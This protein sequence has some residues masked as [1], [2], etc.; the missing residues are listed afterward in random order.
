MCSYT[1]IHR[2][3]K[4]SQKE[5]QL[6]GR[7][8]KSLLSGVAAPVAVVT[9]ASRGLYKSTTMLAAPT[10]LNPFFVSIDNKTS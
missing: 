9:R 3:S 2:T 7:D 8:L 5:R 4:L 6:H 10:N 1:D